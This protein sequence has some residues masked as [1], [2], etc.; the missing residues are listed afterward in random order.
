MAVLPQSLLPFTPNPNPIA[1]LWTGIQEFMSVT[2]LPEKISGALS[3]AAKAELK[4]RLRLNRDEDDAILRRLE[5][6][7]AIFN[8]HS[9]FRHLLVAAL[10]ED[11]DGLDLAFHATSL[12]GTLVTKSEL[13]EISLIASPSHELIGKSSWRHVTDPFQRAVLRHR[14]LLWD[15]PLADAVQDILPTEDPEEFHRAALGVWATLFP[16]LTWSECARILGALPTRAHLK[17]FVVT[18][19]AGVPEDHPLESELVRI[20]ARLPHSFARVPDTLC[21]DHLLL[22]LL[23]DPRTESLGLRLVVTAHASGGSDVARVFTSAFDAVPLSPGWYDNRSFILR[24]RRLRPLDKALPTRDPRSSRDAALKLLAQWETERKVRDFVEGEPVLSHISRELAA[25]APQIPFEL[26]ETVAATLLE[27]HYEKSLPAA[28]Q[29]NLVHSLSLIGG[30]LAGEL[31]DEIQAIVVKEHDPETAASLWIASLGRLA[32]LGNTRALAALKNMTERHDAN[33]K[34]ALA[35]LLRIKTDIRGLDLAPFDLE[36]IPEKLWQGVRVSRRQAE[37]ILRQRDCHLNGV[38]LAGS[39][40]S[41]AV[42][43][44]FRIHDVDFSDAFLAGADFSETGFEDCSLRGTDATGADFTGAKFSNCD[45]TNLDATRA[46]LGGADLSDADLRTVEIADADITSVI[47]AHDLRSK[48]KG[49]IAAELS[50][51]WLRRIPGSGALIGESHLALLHAA[52]LSWEGLA[53]LRMPMAGR[54]FPQGASLKNS[55]FTGTPLEKVEFDGNDLTNS[56]FDGATVKGCVFKGANLTGIRHENT[57]VVD[58]KFIG[59]ILPLSFLNVV[60]FSGSCDFR[61]QALSA[62]ELRALAQN[63]K[64]HVYLNREHVLTCLAHKIPLAGFILYDLDL[65]GLDF[66]G[67]NLRQTYLGQSNFI[68]AKFIQADLQDA[69]LRMTNL[70]GAIFDGAD[71]RGANLSDQKEPLEIDWATQAVIRNAE[72]SGRRTPAW[73]ENSMQRIQE[74]NNTPL[75]KVNATGASFRGTKLNGS[76]LYA[77]ILKDAIFD[78]DQLDDYGRPW[79]ERTT[80]VL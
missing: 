48:P 31:K 65:S 14:A 38:V 45:L 5:I 80:S 52:G 61:Q 66:S 50:E 60:D 19:L 29:K 10:A 46:K 64:H 75:P 20:L 53:F 37:E 70:K 2:V 4:K 78:D 42:W 34:Q 30:H 76:S 71:L 47:L 33:S 3:H 6:N 17:D 57:R 23:R 40:L 39:D 26:R 77:A 11:A 15:T 74:Y 36:K 51:K 67:Q 13:I 62:D 12:G 35:E 27:L 9:E 28:W 41:G 44:K 24:E 16:T 56:R 58:S 54:H 49:R 21:L 18:A 69:D 73:A 32:Q 22:D 1:R 8:K 25:L 43:K 79:R 7:L 63:P 68:G 59:A 55:D 72:R